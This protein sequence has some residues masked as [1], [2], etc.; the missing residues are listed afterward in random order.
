MEDYRRRLSR[1]VSEK[2]RGAATLANKTY[3]SAWKGTLK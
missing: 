1:K 3:K 2:I